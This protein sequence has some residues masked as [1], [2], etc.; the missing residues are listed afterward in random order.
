LARKEFPQLFVKGSQEFNIGKMLDR[1][2]PG[3]ATHPSRNLVIGDYLRGAKMRIEKSAKA[4]ERG[5]GAATNGAEKPT[6][7]EALTRNQNG[8]IPPIAPETARVPSNSPAVPQ[9][10]KLV[11]DATKNV[12]AE[13]GAIDSIK[14]LILAKW[15]ANRTSVTDPKSA[16]AV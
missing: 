8:H 1:E 5:N 9:A 10:R 6:L 4:N 11:A 2:L 14:Q 16:A 15:K 3:L 7:P 12:I 13:G